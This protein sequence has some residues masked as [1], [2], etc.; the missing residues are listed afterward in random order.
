VLSMAENWWRVAPDDEPLA[1]A[2]LYRLGPEKFTD[3]V[4]LAWAHAEAGAHDR[5]WHAMATLPERWTAPAFPLRA[6]DF[7]ARGVAKGPALGAALA[8]AEAAWIKAGFPA[9]AGALARI[10]D[11]AAQGA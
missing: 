8:V 3:R 5:D 9:D 10:A 7:M 1:R 6:A 11:V 4:L 2:L